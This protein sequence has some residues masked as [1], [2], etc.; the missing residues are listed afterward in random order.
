MRIERLISEWSDTTQIGRL[1]RSSGKEPVMVSQEVYE[2][3]QR[4]ITVAEMTQGAFDITFGGAGKLWNFDPESPEIPDSVSVKH[5]L[6][7][8]GYKNIQLME[9]NKIFLMEPGMQ[10][11]FGGIG[12]GYAAE[13][14]KRMM[15]AKGI[16]GGVINASGDLTAWGTDA[17]GKPWKVG[18]ADPED[19][20]KILLWLPVEDEAVATSGNYEKYVMINGERYG[21]IIDPRTGYPAKGIKSVTIFSSSA[22]LSDALATA[23]FVMGTE[24]GLDFIGQLPD[25]HCIIVDDENQVHYSDSINPPPDPLPSG[26]EGE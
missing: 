14:V 19:P 3:I 21:H 5:A 18:I 9:D 4:S 6:K 22:E 20:S 24:V 16:T 23:V 1:N 10:I 7:S 25:T 26:M 12:K 17:E 8:V 11:G 2:L 15:L 13:S